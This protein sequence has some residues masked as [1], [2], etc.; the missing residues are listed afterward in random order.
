MSKTH[1]QDTPSS[2][3]PTKQYSPL[4]AAVPFSQTLPPLCL[5]LHPPQ[6]SSTPPSAKPP[7]PIPATPSTPSSPPS[8]P[9]HPPS[10]AP[11]RL[12]P[13]QISERG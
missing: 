6:T 8:A 12:S 10:F 2:N 13:G 11:S 7:T 5:S 3:L 1:Q 4:P 9:L